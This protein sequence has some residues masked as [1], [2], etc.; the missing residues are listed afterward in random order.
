METLGGRVKRK[1]EEKGWSQSDL[2]LEVK[3][4]NRS[5]TTRQST[6]AAIEDGTSKKPTILYELARALGVSDEWLK[7]GKEEDYPREA[8]ESTGLRNIDLIF[9]AVKGSYLMLGLD[10]DE[11]EALVQIVREV[12]EEPPTPSASDDLQT[13]RRILAESATRRFLK[14]KPIQ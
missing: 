4:V 6:I 9:S 3:R 5:L 11:A 8:T 13:S 12:C 2:A 1:R 14:S 7:T 10:Q